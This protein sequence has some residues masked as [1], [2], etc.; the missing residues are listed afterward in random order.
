MLRPKDNANTIFAHQ[1]A[2]GRIFIIIYSYCSKR[3]Y[4]VQQKFADK[5][6]IE[7]K[8]LLLDIYKIQL[9]V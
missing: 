9:K 5:G 7:H 8:E 6:C 1:T 4:V 2:S 3:C